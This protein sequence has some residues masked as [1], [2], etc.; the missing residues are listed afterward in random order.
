M[1]SHFG[2]IVA[3]PLVLTLLLSPGEAKADTKI[4]ELPAKAKGVLKAYCYHCHGRDGRAE[5]GFNVVIDLAKLVETKKVIPG[6]AAESKLLRRVVEG[7]MPPK[8][9]FEAE[10]GAKPPRPKPEE[11]E[12][13]RA[14]I[15]AGAPNGDTGPGAL[16]P[17]LLTE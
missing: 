12:I 10:D 5:G 15:D 13:L 2:A 14:W 6:K 8:E 7:S 1:P 17:V 9:D 16:R 4:S 11:V 3:S